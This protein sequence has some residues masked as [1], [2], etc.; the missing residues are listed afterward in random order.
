MAGVEV[1]IV[2]SQQAQAQ[3]ENKPRRKAKR[4]ESIRQ[5]HIKT[6]EKIN[7]AFDAE[8]IPETTRLL[9]KL[10]KEPDLNNIEKAYL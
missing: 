5:K 9:N 1:T 7:E 8:N 6:F 2:D 10:E 4:V 3:E